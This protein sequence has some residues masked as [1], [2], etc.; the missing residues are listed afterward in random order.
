M[1]KI[2]YLPPIETV[3][4]TIF[5][6]KLIFKARKLQNANGEKI[7]FTQKKGTRTTPLT[8]AEIKRQERFAAIAAMVVERKKSPTLSDDR[9]A[10]AKT[11]YKSFNAYLW[12]VCG[13]EYDQKQ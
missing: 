6:K 3:H 13:T 1:A 2:N 11:S 5:N 4:G 9:K 7:N 8:P 12:A 10:Y